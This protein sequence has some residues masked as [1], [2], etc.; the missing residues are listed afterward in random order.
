MS[1]AKRPNFLLVMTDQQRADSVGFAQE[2]GG[3]GRGGSDT[4]HLDS[5]AQQGVIF[6]N[7]Y[8]ASTVC[9][10]ARTA[11][12][13]GIFA[14]RLPR[15]E[16]GL[17]LKEG[18]WTIAHAMA[19]AGYETALFGKM[20]FAPIHARHGFEVARS[21][22]HLAAGYQPEDA[23]DYRRWLEAQGL[24]DPRQA[25]ASGFP[26]DDALHPEH[27]IT[28]QAIDF[29]EERQSSLPFF[30]IVSYTGPHGP[31]IPSKRYLDMYPWAAETIPADGFE[32]NRD[33]PEVF[34][35]VLTRGMG[36]HRVHPVSAWS[37]EQVKR[38]LAAVRAM[39][40]QIDD[41]VARLMSH[42]SL[43]D[44][45][46]FFTSD[47]GGYY[48]HRG[49]ILK[50]P[51][52][53]FDDLAKVPFFALG[54]GVEGD[55]RVAAPVQSCDFAATCLELADLEPPTRLD[56]KSL[57]S[58]LHGGPEDADRDVFCGSVGC[59]MIR[60]GNHKLLWHETGI[61][62]LYDLESDPGE[63]KNL[64]PDRPAI[65]KTLRDSLVKQ[66]EQ[67]EVDLWVHLPA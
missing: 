62:V 26:Y 5:L 51:W 11:L 18:C 3:G 10:P 28:D 52:L 48:G 49:L 67:P 1:V 15:V 20:H 12:L 7:A 56:T 25:G 41:Q 38:T 29:L 9:V 2:M 42:V 21:C 30:T 44:T 14:E 23:D 40:R 59:Q 6:E 33:L 16:G 22:E 47:H 65:T 27:W 43:D 45:V 46:V 55:R 19:R 24:A 57:V 8:S 63:T 39:I 50:T 53:P 32:V 61:E 35:R 31:Y 4:P 66:I 37:P 36:R 17:A 64:A 54:M 60:R 58:V 13:T 34:Q